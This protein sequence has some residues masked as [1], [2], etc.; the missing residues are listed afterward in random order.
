MVD[1]NGI[2]NFHQKNK[3]EQKE[4]TSTLKEIFRYKYIFIHYNAGIHI[5]KIIFNL[6]RKPEQMKVKRELVFTD[7]NLKSG[8]NK[9]KTQKLI[10]YICYDKK[11]NNP[12]NDKIIIIDEIH[13]LISSIAGKG[14]TTKIIYQLLLRAKNTKIICLSGTPCINRP[15][16]I[17]LLMN[18]LSGYK[19]KYNFIFR[20]SKCRSKLE[21]IIRKDEFIDFSSISVNIDGYLELS[22]TPNPYYFVNQFDED[23]NKIG[24]KYDSNKLQIYKENGFKKYIM[25]KLE[26]QSID[27]LD[28]NS[29]GRLPFPEKVDEFNLK[30]IDNSENKIKSKNDFVSRI[31]GKVSFFNETTSKEEDGGSVFPQLLKESDTKSMLSPYQFYKYSEAR[32]LERKTEKIKGNKDDSDGGYYRVVSRNALLFTFPPKIER[33]WP[34]TLNA[35]YN[36][37]ME[38]EGDTDLSRYD[39]TTRLNEALTQLESDEDYLTYGNNKKYDLKVLSPKYCS[40][41]QNIQKS[42]GLVLCYSQYKTVE[43]IRVFTQVLNKHGYAP[44][45]IMED[46]EINATNMVRFKI[47]NNLVITVRIADIKDGFYMINKQEVEDNL[48]SACSQNKMDYLKIYTD[49]CSKNK[50]ETIDKFYPHMTYLT[51]TNTINDYFSI[52]IETN[53]DNIHRACYSIWE[54]KKVKKGQLPIIDTFN[55]KEN[56]FGDLVSI[57]FI[58]KSGAE[59]ISLFNVRQVNIMEPYWNMILIDQVIG[60]ARRISSHIN[61]P[62]EQRNVKVFEYI[63]VFSNK[64]IDGDWVDKDLENLD[65]FIL[66]EGWEKIIEN[67]EIFYHNIKT[68]EKTI[69]LPEFE[70]EDL[71]RQLVSMKS[72]STLI[73]NEDRGLSSDEELKTISLRKNNIIVKFLQLMRNA[74]VDCEYNKRD[75][76]ET[77]KTDNLKCINTDSLPRIENRFTYVPDMI[78]SKVT[79]TKSIDSKVSS[80]KILVTFTL[81]EYN[82]CFMVEKIPGVKKFP[83]IDIYRY[84]GL[85]PIVTSGSFKGEQV[86]ILEIDYNDKYNFYLDNNFLQDEERLSRYDAIESVRSKLADMKPIYK[87]I[88]KSNDGFLSWVNLIRNSEE[89][90]KFKKPPIK[91][92]IDRD[93]S[94]DELSSD[95]SSDSSDDVSL[96]DGD[97]FIILF[98]KK[99][100]DI[101][102]LNTQDR[103]NFLKKAMIKL[104]S[105]GKSILLKRAIEIAQEIKNIK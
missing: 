63:G 49:F 18:I 93:I 35:R 86:G 20:D 19:T 38:K 61:L 76:E 81:R 104:R 85:D 64:Q 21:E 100:E 57:L 7:D 53:K 105:E 3:K 55:S 97:E 11:V 67:E 31:I 82:L 51:E 27:I 10:K 84:F 70:K 13:N 17:G 102:K 94:D 48:R 89:L 45:N 80:E 56:V 16:E 22:L 62:K 12:F 90:S 54:G 88:P 72:Y 30:Y 79:I 8:L 15:F 75:N 14:Y 6:L 78:G 91:L 77:L 1:P 43:G 83:L 9:D 66:P 52:N 24:I 40:I 26:D 23:N 65:I 4:I 29:K 95:G 87:S 99:R 25:K 60:R 74:A 33:V 59:G 37:A 101:I 103:L 39:Y 34:A 28:E 5:S 36:Q 42:P 92:N 41:F 47:E 2:P 96:N 50:V 98:G 73:V 44:Y 32:E 46:Y 69:E 68:G 71:S 58:T